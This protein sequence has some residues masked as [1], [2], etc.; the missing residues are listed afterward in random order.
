MA[1][2]RDR[3]SV[4]DVGLG[5]L[6]RWSIRL[7]VF[8]ASAVVLGWIVG[9]LWMV[10]FPVVMALIVST[11]LIPPA[12]WMR[13]V[14]VPSAIA[15]TVVMLGFLA[16]II[17][18]IATLLP[19]VVNQSSEIAQGASEGLAKIQEWIVDGPLN[20]TQSDMTQLLEAAQTKLQESAGVISSGVFSTLGAATNALINIV[21]ILMLTFFFVKDGYKFIPWAHQLAGRR[22]GLHLVNV[23]ERV[24]ATL[25]G[26]IRT[27]GLVSLIDAVIIGAG[28]LIIG[29]P[30]AVPLAVLTFI[31]G[32]IPIVGALIT[33]A[34]AVLVT[35][36]TNGPQ[37]A[38][39]VLILILVVQQLEGN[40]LSP[41]LQG[42]TMDLHPAVVLLAVTAGATLFGITGAFLAVPVTASATAVLRY[43]NEQVD[44]KVD[45][46]APPEDATAAE[47]T[48]D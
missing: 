9:H 3:A 37:E 32:F 19:T 31:G 13:R 40:V 26:F 24:W 21:L 41:W 38:L 5:G 7:I 27:Q 2:I 17:G 39:I 48:D 10:F 12:A 14:G 28:L 22:A 23:L 33:G 42:R 47:P 29:V 45:A 8:A 11:V 36:V 15:A 6:T 18:G 34:L 25:G 20:I 30:L 35:L 46:G 43:I 4:I 1:S 16:I 44:R